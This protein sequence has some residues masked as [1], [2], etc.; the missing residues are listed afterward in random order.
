MG[1]ML[2][3]YQARISQEYVMDEVER[4]S[5]GHKEEKGVGK[6]PVSHNVLDKRRLAHAVFWVPNTSLTQEPCTLQ[7]LEYPTFIITPCKQLRQQ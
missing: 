5:V 4:I 3:Q 6:H 2:K 7:V 1:T